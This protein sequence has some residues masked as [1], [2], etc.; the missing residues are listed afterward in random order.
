MPE[1][2]KVLITAPTPDSSEQQYTF[3]SCGQSEKANSSSF[4]LPIKMIV[5]KLSQLS[6]APQPIFVTYS[7]KIIEDILAHPLNAPLPIMKIVSGKFTDLRLIQFSNAQR[8][9]R[10]TFGIIIEDRFS[11]SLNTLSPIAE[12]LFDKY[13]FFKLE[14]S[15]KVPSSIL[16]MP[17]GISIDSNFVHPKK[18]YSPILSRL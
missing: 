3:N 14:Q 2:I 4:G 9:I 18:A 12:T 6:K 15:L 8:S 7:G 16:F 1:S 10:D 5:L 11:Q 17:L 13:T